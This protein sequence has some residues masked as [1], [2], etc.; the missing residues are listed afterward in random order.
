MIKLFLTTGAVLGAVVFSQVWVLAQEE[1]PGTAP[2][3]SVE[4]DDPASEML[5][6]GPVEAVDP[7]LE[8]TGSALEAADPVVEETDPAL[9]AADPLVE[10]ADPAL[11]A[12]DPAVEGEDPPLEAADGEAEGSGATVEV[13]DAQLEQVAGTLSKLQVVEEDA[14]AQITEAIAGQGLTEER[15]M[16]IST[17]KQAAPDAEVQAEVSPVE[18]QQYEQ[19]L[20][21]IETI[22]SAALQQQEEI[23]Q[24]E[25]FDIE[26]FN[27]MLGTIQSDP[28][29]YEK[30]RNMTSDS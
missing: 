16:E 14:K 4:I 29:L 23:I 21:E 15:F 22:D 3:D 8:D 9:E 24:A 11:E 20:A 27:Q 28:E 10:D 5:E 18:D 17:A 26:E 6:S 19:A 2:I 25:G 30:V 1:L 12:A 7:T 13:S